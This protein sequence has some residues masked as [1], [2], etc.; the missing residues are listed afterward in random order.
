MAFR[1][2]VHPICDVRVL[3]AFSF[4]LQLTFFFFYFALHSSSHLIFETHS[5]LCNGMCWKI[6]FSCTIKGKWCGKLCTEGYYQ[7]KCVTVGG[8]CCSERNFTQVHSGPFT[9][10]RIFCQRLAMRHSKEKKGYANRKLCGQQSWRLASKNVCHILHHRQEL[11]EISLSDPRQGHFSVAPGKMV[12][13]LPQHLAVSILIPVSW[14]KQ[15]NSE[16]HQKRE[17]TR[18]LFTL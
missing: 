9:V 16:E 1:C 11:V 18:I 4:Q 7:Q 2:T 5:C 3:R 17:V 12:A 15:G 13:S 6:S 10:N 8:T 14:L